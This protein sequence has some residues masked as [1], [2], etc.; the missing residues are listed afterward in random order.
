MQQERRN[1]HDHDGYEWDRQ[2]DTVDCGGGSDTVVY[3][4]RYDTVTNCENKDGRLS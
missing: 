2:P 4:L 3:D 1:A